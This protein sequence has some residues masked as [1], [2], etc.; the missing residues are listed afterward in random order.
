M[1][2]AAIA[3]GNL[4]VVRWQSVA[5][6]GEIVAAQIGGI[7]TAEATVKSLQWINGH[8]WLMPHNPDYQPLPADDAVVLGNVVAVIRPAG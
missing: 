7:A 4:I 2:G 5:E 1:T 6:S 3:D 8:A